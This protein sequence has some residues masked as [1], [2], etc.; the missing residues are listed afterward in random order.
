M[1]SDGFSTRRLR[2]GH[3]RG[4]TPPPSRHWS[5][6]APDA[7]APLPS[8]VPPVYRPHRV[9]PQIAPGDPLS[10]LVCYQAAEALRADLLLEQG[11]VYL[12]LAPT[13]ELRPMQKVMLHLQL[14]LGHYVTL[15]ARVWE[16]THRGSALVARGVSPSVMASLRM[17]LDGR[18]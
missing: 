2:R 13:T 4:S 5:N 10:V 14:P 1:A 9:T 12:F 16:S 7:R 8:I 6:K 11:N 15:E 3:S 18:K 17:A